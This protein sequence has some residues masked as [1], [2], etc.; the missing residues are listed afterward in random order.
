MTNREITQ[1]RN[2]AMKLIRDED[3]V[4]EVLYEIIRQNLTFP[5]AVN[6]LKLTA[7]GSAY[8]L[9]AKRT[10]RRSIDALNHS[11]SLDQIPPDADDL[12]SEFIPSEDENPQFN[13]DLKD[14]FETLTNTEIEILNLVLEGFTVREICKLK[15]ISSKTYSKILSS[16]R[17]KALEFFT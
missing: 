2:L 14:F 17:K 13:I 7:R 9:N 16:I 10:G 15:K 11:T 1:L 3:A 6:Y 4:Q 8:K 5:L 12:L